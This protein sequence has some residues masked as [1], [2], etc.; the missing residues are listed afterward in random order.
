M[1][2]TTP[3][4][5]GAQMHKSHRINAFADLKPGSPRGILMIFVAAAATMVQSNRLFFR[6]RTGGI[7]LYS[8]IGVLVRTS[9]PWR[10]ASRSFHDAAYLLSPKAGMMRRGLTRS[11]SARLSDTRGCTFQ[12]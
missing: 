12:R 8:A 7:P 3:A 11:I 5:G 2:L 6:E 9:H 1:L 4:L 10:C